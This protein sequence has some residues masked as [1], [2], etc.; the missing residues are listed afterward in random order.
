M[1]EI[2][3]ETVI[4]R[5]AAEVWDAIRDVGHVDT[6]L[7]PGFVRE[8]RMEGDERIVGFA[9]GFVVREVI[10]DV[11]DAE[12]RLAYSA[13]SERLHRHSAYFQVH[14]DGPERCRVV[15]TAY[16]QPDEAAKSVAAMMEEGAA[17]MK[18]TLEAARKSG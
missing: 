11:D 4:A 12:R 9:N 13:R 3:K 18:K 8:C 7:A 10:I 2:R 1:P 6:R 5:P 16:V 17:V 14:E 15:W